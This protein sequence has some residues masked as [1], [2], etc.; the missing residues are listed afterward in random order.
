MKT[1]YGKTNIYNDFPA[2][3]NRVVQRLH[4]SVSIS[5]VFFKRPCLL[6]A[7]LIIICSFLC[8]YSCSVWPAVAICACLLSVCLWLI[9]RRPCI[10]K[11]SVIVTGLL[12]S[13]SLLYLGT[14][15]SSHLN[16]YAELTGGSFFC[17]VTDIS[18]DLSGDA[19]ITVKLDNGALAKLKFYEE[20]PSVDAGDELIVYGKLREA[21]NAG[22]PGEF[23]YSEYLRDKGILYVLSGTGYET[24]RKASFPMSFIGWFKKFC[25]DI[26]EKT[27]DIV[28]VN[29]SSSEKGLISAVCT[30]DRSL[31]DKGVKRD[32]KMSCCSHLLAVSG[33]HFSG[34]LMCLPLLL[35]L[36][37]ISRKKGIVIYVISAVVI[38]CL[39]GWSESV[40]RAAVMSIC[41]FADRDWLSA[42][43]VSAIIMVLADPFCPM[44]SGFQMSFCAVIAIKVYSER[45]SGF[46][47]K[48][49]FGEALSKI[50][51]VSISAWLGMIPFWSDISMRPDTEH[52]VLQI[53]ASFIAQTACAFFVPCVLLC[54]IFPFWSEFLSMPIKL[55]L[56]LLM[57]L[58]SFGA[59]LSEQGGT[60]IHLSQALLSVLSCFVFLV[61]LKP[62]FTKRIF[63]KISALLLAV[64]IGFEVFSILNKPSCVVVFADVGQGDCCLIITPEKTCLIDAGTYSEGAS[65]VSDLL[66]YYGIYQVDICFMSHWDADHAG[67]FAALYESGRAI[68]FLCSYVPGEDD[69]DKDVEEFFKAVDYGSDL[70]DGFLSC[71]E[72]VSSGE[73]ISVSESVYIDVL[74]P[75]V[76]SGGGNENSLVLMLH[77]SGTEEISILFTGDVGSKTEALLIE[78]GIDL[79]CDILKVAHHGSKYSSSAD[80]ITAVSPDIAVISVGK[81]NF[82]GHPAPETVERLETYCCTVFRTDE[83]GAVVMEY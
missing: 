48:L 76:S 5:E 22:N 64:M 31:I 13:L 77:V 3:K 29:C 36:L 61:M 60:V 8:F 33:T 9:H 46:L 41:L 49:H 57:K 74:Y 43:S 66:D 10:N 55:S 27:I 75:S 54:F 62:C 6:P 11:V 24:V 30:G 72:C 28:S 58:I 80:F 40:T 39:T 23:D 37:K 63:L 83:E 38:G 53:A 25:F 79:D 59:Y 15:I 71:C 81:N 20:I 19:D 50:V 1:I 70:R 65:T 17:S 12:I 34:F 52:L 2:L 44:S 18:Y 35:N 4:D 68:S 26:R 69:H 16:A 51:S 45:I 78:S 47:I 7:L 73:C 32:F 42:L 67:G 21:E 56:Q 14:F 82:Y